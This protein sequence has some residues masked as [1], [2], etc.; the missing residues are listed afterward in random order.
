VEALI[1]NP[2]SKFSS[3]SLSDGP[4]DMLGWL[5]H[6]YLDVHLEGRPLA[7]VMGQERADN[8]DLFLL[9][10]RDGV[11]LLVASTTG[12]ERSGG[13]SRVFALVTKGLVFMVM[14]GTWRNKLVLSLKSQRVS[15]SELC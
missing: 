9:K 3:M 2:N 7:D 10:I 12:S 14:D 13:N 11:F 8:T 15:L 5:H 1:L 6:L 4:S